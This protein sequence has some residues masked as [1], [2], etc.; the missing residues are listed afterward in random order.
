M[1]AA[2][3]RMSGTRSPLASTFRRGSVVSAISRAIATARARAS[4]AL[5]DCD[6]AAEYTGCCAA[7]AAAACV[8]AT[9]REAFARALLAGAA[10]VGVTPI[11]TRP[12]SAREPIQKIGFLFTSADPDL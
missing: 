5:R 12:R 1:M 6:R 3:A 10:V 7:R 2:A 9:D 11:L 8:A 4:F